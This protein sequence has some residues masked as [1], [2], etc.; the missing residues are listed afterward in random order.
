[1]AFLLFLFARATDIELRGH[2]TSLLL[3]VWCGGQPDVLQEFERLKVHSCSTPSCGTLS[4]TASCESR[5]PCARRLEFR[6][7]SRWQKHILLLGVFESL[8]SVSVLA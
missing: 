6:S 7:P 5:R 2:V 3:E 4:R 1:M 8:R